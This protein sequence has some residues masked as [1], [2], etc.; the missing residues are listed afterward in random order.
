[1][2]GGRLTKRQLL[3]LGRGP[4]LR[5]GRR[6]RT[7]SASS[8]HLPG[9]SATGERLWL[10]GTG[11]DLLSPFLLGLPTH[12]RS[13][14]A[15]REHGGRGA[16]VRHRTRNPVPVPKFVRSLTRCTEISEGSVMD[17][18]HGEMVEAELTC[19]IEK[20]SSREMDSDDEREELWQE[21]VMTYNARGR[22]EKRLAWCKH[23]EQAER[24]RAVER[25]QDRCY[26]E[27]QL[28]GG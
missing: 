17:V 1:V 2:K 28:R 3:R 11:P 27:P 12:G 13:T 19:L 5:T 8:A 22:E 20:R 7:G 26:Y 21:S 10:D 16:A 6:A 24:R 23:H 4:V 15:G 18:A 14:S 9:E 25:H